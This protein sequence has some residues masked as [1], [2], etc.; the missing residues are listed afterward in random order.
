MLLVGVIQAVLPEPKLES[1]YSD[2]RALFLYSTF[3]LNKRL[4]GG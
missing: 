1:G 4:R 3:F 2:F